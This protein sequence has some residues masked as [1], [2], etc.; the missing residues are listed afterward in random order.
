MNLGELKWQDQAAC[1]PYPQEWWFPNAERSS[2]QYAAARA[3]C[4]QCPVQDECL[5]YAMA[6]EEP[7]YEYGMWGGLAPR[8]RRALRRAVT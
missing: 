8:Q 1:K 2:H 5:A 6:H 7:H 4:E 3:V